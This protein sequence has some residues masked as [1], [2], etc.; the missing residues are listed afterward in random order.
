MQ[1][2]SN[3]QLEG[4]RDQGESRRMTR[5]ALERRKCLI[6]SVVEADCGERV[7]NAKQHRDT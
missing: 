2:I 7:S 5:V 4:E 3:E 6:L 1:F